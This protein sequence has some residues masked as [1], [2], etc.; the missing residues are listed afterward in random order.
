MIGH[1]I[2]SEN[3]TVFGGSMYFFYM[4]RIVNMLEISCTSVD[5]L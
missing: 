5:L 4:D 2:Y 3:V 1:L